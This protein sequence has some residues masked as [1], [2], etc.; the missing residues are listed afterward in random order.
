MSPFRIVPSCMGLAV[1]PKQCNYLCFCSVESKW[2]VLQWRWWCQL[3]DDHNLINLFIPYQDLKD[4]SFL[5]VINRYVEVHATVGGGV[6]TLLLAYIRTTYSIQ[7]SGLSLVVIQ[8][9]CKAV[10]CIDIH[11]SH[12]IKGTSNVLSCCKCYGLQLLLTALTSSSSVL[13]SLWYT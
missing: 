1:K 13:I 2:I 6:S 5:E 11:F 8:W 4:K 9:A 10:N 7:Q 12:K 3:T